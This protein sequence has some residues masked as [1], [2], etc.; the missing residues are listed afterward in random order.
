MT[1]TYDNIIANWDG[2]C[3]YRDWYAVDS[4][5][6]ITGRV[7]RLYVGDAASACKMAAERVR[8]DG[9]VDYEGNPCEPGEFGPALFYRAT[10][11]DARAAHDYMLAQSLEADELGELIPVAQA[12]KEL[13]IARQSAYGLVERGAIPSEECAGVRVGRYSVALRL[14]MLG[15]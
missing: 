8:G 2:D 3:E 15:E 4:M 14:A 7:R 12:A 6:A 10:L 11:I 5:D 9:L 13:G 1:E